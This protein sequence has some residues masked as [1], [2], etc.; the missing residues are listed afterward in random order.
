MLPTR[1]L[2]Y[3][4]LAAAFSLAPWAAEAT[5]AIQFTGTVKCEGVNADGSKYGPVTFPVSTTGTN[6]NVGTVFDRWGPGRPVSYGGAKY[7]YG[8]SP[9]N[10]TIGISHF[11]GS[12][13]YAETGQLKLKTDKAGKTKL[14]GD[15]IMYVT[16]LPTNDVTGGPPI[17]AD[18]DWK[19]TAT[20]YFVP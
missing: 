13:G 14:E 12:E 8:V 6:G 4:S 9:P 7:G 16:H 17:S 3:V 20:P 10:G 15:S 2:L 18:C 5:T 11:D 1:K 19:L